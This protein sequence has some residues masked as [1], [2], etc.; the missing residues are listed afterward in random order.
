MSPEQFAHFTEILLENA[1]QN[2]DVLGVVFLGS[3]ADAHRRDSWS[4]HDMFWVVKSG[5]QEHYRQDLSW[6]PYPEQIVMRY[7]ETQH[8]VNVIYD[9][10]HLI[11][12]AVFDLDE[13]N[14]VKAND[15][16]VPLD[17]ADIEQRM[18]SAVKNTTAERVEAVIAARHLMQIV[19]A[20]IGRWARGEKIS[21]HAFVR[22]YA[23]RRLLQVL[24]LV[25]QPEN[26]AKLDSLDPYRRFE[27]VLPE[28]GAQIDNLL[29]LDVPE[30][31]IGY[32][33]LLETH[34][35]PHIQE[36]PVELAET[37]RRH[38]QKARDYQHE[39]HHNHGND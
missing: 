31:A 1:R 8:G 9:F 18:A 2:P 32:L 7:R 30:C 12:F 22:M 16:A 6:L 13:L 21:A 24:P 34:V 33:D 27:Q 19:F 37:V 28:L 14:E 35:K 39:H 25:L 20:G 4:D 36:Y 29:R 17:K 38:I 11:E 15:Y 26:V 10:G 23:L 3:A 5:R